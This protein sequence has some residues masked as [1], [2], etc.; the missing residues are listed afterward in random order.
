MS[1]I[2]TNTG[3]TFPDSTSQSTAVYGIGVA[4]T[5]LDFTGS[6]AIGPTY[7]NTTSKPIMVSIIS[8]AGNITIDVQLWINDEIRQRFVN[9]PNSSAIGVTVAGIIPPGSSYAFWSNGII[10]SWLELR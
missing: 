3:I 6:R 7:T 4:Q 8:T 10:S 9:N 5:W 1:V 2:L